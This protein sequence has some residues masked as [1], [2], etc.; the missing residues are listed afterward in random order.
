M[1]QTIMVYAGNKL[2][3]LGIGLPGSPI[4]WNFGPLALMIFGG[5]GS[6]ALKDKFKDE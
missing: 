2:A 6:N 5:I 3:G 1:D 4:V